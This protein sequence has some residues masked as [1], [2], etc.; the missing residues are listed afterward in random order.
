MEGTRGGKESLRK[1]F[2]MGARW[3]N[4]RLRGEGRVQEE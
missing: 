3:R 2:E 1:I 4:A